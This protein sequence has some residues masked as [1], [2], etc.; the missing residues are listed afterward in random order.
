MGNIINPL[1]GQ[2]IAEQ[3]RHTLADL[4]AAV[5]RAREAQAEWYGAGLAYRSRIIRNLAPLIADRT[6]QLTDVICAASGS[7]SAFPSRSTL[8]MDQAIV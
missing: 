6:K 5:A 3:Q 8:A 2:V 4:Q 7:G 1:T